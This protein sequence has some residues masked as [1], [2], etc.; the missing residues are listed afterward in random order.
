MNKKRIKEIQK[1]Q[2]PFISLS[3]DLYTQFKPFRLPLALTV[4]MMMFGSLGYV[5]IDNFTLMDAIY[6]TGITFT[7]VGFGEISEISPAGRVFT[8]T[9]IILGFGVFSFSIGVLV[10]VLN[11]GELL[12]I[13]KE[14]SMLY[15]VARL[16][17]HFV[18]CYHNEY[19]TQLT[20]E[21]R[22]N[23][24]PFVVI[25]PSKELEEI[26]KKHNYPYYIQ[27]EPH[28]EAAVLKSYMASA[29]GVISLSKNMADNIAQIASVRL[30]EREIEKSKP[31]HIICNAESSS[32]VDKLKKLGA[33]TVVSPT[34]LMAQRMSAMANRPDM[35][36][37]LEEF[38]YKGNSQIDMEEIAVPK[39][40]WMT[41]QKL[42]DTHLREFVNV[43]VI[44][45]KERDGK[46]IAMPRGNRVISRECILL[47]VGTTKGILST[48]RLINKDVKPEELKYV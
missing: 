31:Y 17:Q 5:F 22:Y 41:L 36:N 38:L 13:L 20:K 21:L 34:K 10:E 4:L 29:K 2:K 32:D 19:T 24:I 40:S 14:R 28:T 48:K 37:L 16:K 46:F 15:K 43:S 45:I 27:E 11:K 18:I 33:D 30:Y 1:K 42:K 23:N 26:A 44:G 8:I 3:G 7:T 35:E 47:V 9:L 25:D 6:Q 12:R 39:H